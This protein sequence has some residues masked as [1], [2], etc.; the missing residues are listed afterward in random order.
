MSLINEMLRDLE[1]R[2]RNGARQLPSGE[3]PIALPRE[4][5]PWRWLL[6]AFAGVVLAGVIWLISDRHILGDSAPT[7]T[8]V[9]SPVA[10]ER[11]PQ[12]EKVSAKA[13]ADAA[14]AQPREMLAAAEVVP[15]PVSESV[16]AAVVE[17]PAVVELPIAVP[18]EPKRPE[19]VVQVAPRQAKQVN[20]TLIPQTPQQRAEQFYRSA[21]QRLQKN[22]LS[23]AAEL[24]LQSLSL[25][26]NLL[27][28]RLLAIDVLSQL[29]R[30]QEAAHLLEVGLQLQPNNFELR[31][32][33]ARSL[34]QQ[35][36]TE[37]A[38]DLLQAKPLPRVAADSEYYALLAALL[39]ETAAYS[40]AADIYRQLLAF[41][42]REPLWWFGLAISAEQAGQK[43][44]AK[45]AYRQALALPGLQPELIDYIN[46]RLQAL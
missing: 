13:S 24:L 18:L 40:E 29:L 9:P 20:K 21:Q 17:P 36:K 4:L 43:S 19:P 26:S 44:E 11:L 27:A 39:R 28:A 1:S 45:D 42:K 6:L 46:G 3:T 16:A 33:S 32:R 41:R 5:I 22:D 37:P 14:E 2:R 25:D 10:A 12:E 15:A 38:L 7:V 31:K 34:L 23:H 35:G 8:P 30:T